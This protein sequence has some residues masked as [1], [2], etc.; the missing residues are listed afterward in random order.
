MKTSTVP[1]R[2]TRDY[3]NG[4]IPS[5]MDSA[6]KHLTDDLNRGR[7]GDPT[8][9]ER[10]ISEKVHSRLK[11]IAGK[12]RGGRVGDSLQTTYLVHEAYLRVVSRNVLELQ[13]RKHFERLV[14][15]VM[16]QVLIDHQRAKLTEKRGAGQVNGVF[17][18]SLDY[19]ED[20]DL[21]LVRLE[22]AVNALAKSNKRQAEIVE[23]K[24]FEG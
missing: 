7:L 5:A 19:S 3:K 4:S 16:K 17:K 14:S 6:A 18:D 2:L 24:N 22:E 10:A 8:A 23:L 9:M 15:L 20:Q 13:S 21:A 11:R 1:E 12:L